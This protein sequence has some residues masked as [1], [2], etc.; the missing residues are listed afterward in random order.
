M[1]KELI[2]KK[3]IVCG[4]KKYCSKCNGSCCKNHVLSLFKFEIDNFPEYS[5]IKRGNKAELREG[6]LDLDMCGQCVFSSDNGCKVPIE[7]RTM[8]CLTYPAYPILNNNDINGF[9]VHNGCAFCEEISKNIKLLKLIKKLWKVQLANR[10][11]LADLNN[12]L[13]EREYW[14]SWYKDSNKISLKD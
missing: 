10:L 2:L 9:Y 1:N 4:F 14:K 13:E 12:F 7:L 6:I 5:L 8:D 11:T 3:K